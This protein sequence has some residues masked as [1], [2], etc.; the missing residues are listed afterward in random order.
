MD[1][2]VLDRESRLRTLCH[3]LLCHSCNEPNTDTARYCSSCGARLE[4]APG[5]TPGARKTVTVV[6][7]DIVE[8]TSLVERLE[9]ETAQRVL[10]RFFDCMRDVVERH[11]GRVEK[12]IGDAVM[13]VFGVPVVHEDDAL[14]AVRA[15]V[16]M[17]EALA[18]LNG[19][20]DGTLGVSIQ[21]RIGVATGEVVTGDP[22]SGKAFVTGDAVNVAA[23]LQAAGTPG[24][25]LVGGS[26]YR[27]IR[28]AVSSEPLGPVELKGKTEAV[29]VHRL[30]GLTAPAQGRRA[31][32]GLRGPSTRARP[33]LRAVDGGLARPRLQARDDHRRCRCREVPPSSGVPEHA[34]RRR[35]GRRRTLPPLRRG[36]HVLAAEGGDRPG[37]RASRGR[38]R[39]RGS[40]AHPRTAARRS[41]RRPRHRAGRGDDR[42]RRCGTRAQGHHVGGRKAHRGGRAETPTDRRARRHPVGRGEVPRSRGTHRPRTR[43]HAATRLVHGTAGTARRSTF[44]DTPGRSLEHRLPEAALRRRLGTAHRDAAGRR[45]TRR[46]AP[47]SA[48]W[49]HRTAC[50]SSSR[51]WSRC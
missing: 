23:R 22:S 1:G 46:R 43:R 51:R 32:R 37:R 45:H 16:G 15:A 25:V 33:S 29:D 40:C 36:H 19:E 48:S 42:H 31:G 9:P 14:R 28:N 41:R 24:D 20:L 10:D 35:G 26:T 38:D 3:M 17:R 50:R 2:A 12:F 27:L 44:V 18:R 11:G 39:R 5:G 49:R 34:D 13:A 7:A 6:F 4:A 30:L 21:M 8:S 47:A